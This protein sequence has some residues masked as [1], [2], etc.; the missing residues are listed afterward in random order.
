M[1][2]LL[3]KNYTIFD[4]LLILIKQNSINLGWWLDNKCLNS[5]IIFSFVGMIDSYKPIQ[6]KSMDEK[7]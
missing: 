5:T 3:L 7:I 1:C 4:N 2:K 6:L